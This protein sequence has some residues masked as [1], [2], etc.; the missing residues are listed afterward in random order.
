[1][2]HPIALALSAES[3]AAAM[4][5]K[6]IP[7]RERFPLGGRLS[8]VCIA[9]AAPAMMPIVPKTLCPVVRGTTLWLW[10]KGQLWKGF[11]N[12]SMRKKEKKPIKVGLHG[13]KVACHVGQ[14][15]DMW[16]KKNLFKYL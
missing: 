2:R 12:S 1:M 16:L 15:S 5:D 4:A 8:A 6:A 7:G 11:I 13:W 14:A 9:P 10:Q 3:A